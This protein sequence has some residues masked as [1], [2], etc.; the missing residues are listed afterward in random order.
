M[1][2]MMEFHRR[3]S[4][5]G[6]LSPGVPGMPGVPGVPGLPGLPCHPQ[7]LADQ[8]TLS[9]PGWADYAHHNTT[10]T[11]GFLDLPMAL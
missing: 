4:G 10:D 6:L 7:I 8:L 11:P 5:V 2:T 3:D 1:S 9:Q